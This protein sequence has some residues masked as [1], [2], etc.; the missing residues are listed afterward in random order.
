MNFIGIFFVVSILSLVVAHLFEA[1]KTHRPK[2]EAVGRKLHGTTIAPPR[3][4]CYEDAETAA[5]ASGLS[6]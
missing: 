5:A 1:L 4:C 2:G 6:E 3:I